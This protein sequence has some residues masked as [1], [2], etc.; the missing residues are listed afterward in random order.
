MNIGI[1]LC[2]R[3]ATELLLA[4]TTALANTEVRSIVLYSSVGDHIPNA[5]THPP[6]VFQIGDLQ[7]AAD[8]HELQ[9]Q[10]VTAKLSDLSSDRFSNLTPQ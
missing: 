9:H 7:I 1:G 10:P 2:R 6:D 8:Y 4:L 3:Q 5:S